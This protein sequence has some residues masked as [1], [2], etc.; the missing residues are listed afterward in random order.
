LPGGF[1]R[2]DIGWRA[3]ARDPIQLD[4]IT[5]RSTRFEARVLAGNAGSDG[6]VATPK[7]VFAD[8]LL[9]AELRPPPATSTA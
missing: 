8:I 4:R 6:R 7:N 2:R 5:P 3:F 1:Y 9:I